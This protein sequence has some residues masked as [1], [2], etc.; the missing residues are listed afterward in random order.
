MH[1]SW[2]NGYSALLDLT[3]PVGDKWFRAQLDRLRNDFHCEYT[4]LQV[5]LSDG[6]QFADA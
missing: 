3:D 6:K 1:V 5:V 4:K 2:W